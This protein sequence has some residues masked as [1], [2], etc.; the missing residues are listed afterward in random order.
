MAHIDAG[1]TTTTERILFYTGKTYKMGE[2]HDGTAV[3]DWMDQEQERGI[4]ITSA[5]TTCLW[6]DYRVNII[7]T[8]GHVDFTAEVERALRAL[9][10]AIIIMCGVGGVEPQTEKVWYQVSKYKI[11]RIAFIN[12][13]DRLGSDYSDVVNQIEEKFAVKT[14]LLQL[15]MGAEENFSG[16]IDLVSQKA[17]KYHEDEEGGIAFDII[18]I[19]GEY[20]EEAEM[21]REHLIEK[22]SDY[23]L[24]LMEL[25]LEKKPVAE[26]K[27]TKAV[28]SA[29]LSLEA[30]PVVMGSAFKKK[31]IQLLLN[32]IVDYLP[33]PVEQPD[34]IGISPTTDKQVTRKL[35]DDAPFSA[36]IFKI[37]SDH[38]IGQLV[39]FR[40][41]SGVMKVGSMVFNSSKGEK[42]RISRLLRM[43]SNKREDV[44]Q[45]YSGDIAATVGLSNVSNAV[46]HANRPLINRVYLAMLMGVG[47]QMMIADPL[48][49][50]QNKVIK[51]IEEKDTSTPLAAAYNKIAER[52][53]VNEEP[54]MGDFD[55]SDPDQAAIWKTTQILLNKVIYADGYLNQ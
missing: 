23:D 44:D 12:K 51:W 48:D 41:Y 5:A 30:V 43:H 31:G 37:M 22:L 15:P 3:M 2:V 9:D 50:E 13:L 49:E 32:A 20:R 27:I 6:N 4:T 29:C 36:L 1:K 42:V 35:S 26:E 45:V 33:S 25:F 28:R 46:P 38:F 14:L 52:S 55:T 24:E 19:P 7:D 17:Y 16:I 8:P 10:G 40:V 11:P 18:D 53:A 21:H 47:L 34:V 39:Y 54:Q